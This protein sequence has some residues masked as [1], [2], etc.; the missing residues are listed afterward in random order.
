M[1]LP[2]SLND[3]VKVCDLR[4]GGEDEEGDKFLALDKPTYKNFVSY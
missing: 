4:W 3:R 1:V 2:P